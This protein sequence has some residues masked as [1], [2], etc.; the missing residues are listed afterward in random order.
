MEPPTACEGA[1]QPREEEPSPRLQRILT[2]LDLMPSASV[3]CCEAAASMDVEVFG[4]R[5]EA[6][7]EWALH[8]LAVRRAPS[9]R[10]PTT[11]AVVRASS[12]LA[13][14]RA[15]LPFASEHSTALVLAPCVGAATSSTEHSTALVLAPCAGAATSSTAAASAAEH[16]GV[17]ARALVLASEDADIERAVDDFMRAVPSALLLH[18]PSAVADLERIASRRRH[19]LSCG[20]SSVRAGTAFVR[21]WL[22]FCERRSL[23]S[24][25][26]PVDD[27]LLCVFFAEVDT[28]ARRRAEGRSRQTGASVLHAMACAARWVT[29]HAGLPF[30]A[31]KARL[32]RK[33]SAPARERDP[34]WSEMWEPSVVV[35]LL[36]V[37]AECAHRGL[38]RAMAASLFFVCTASMRLINGQRSAPPVLDGDGVFHGVAVLSKGKRRSSM[39][40]KPW[41]VPCV[42]PDSAMLDADV[43]RCL[44]E[45]LSSLP[46]SCC[47][48]FPRLIDERGREVS[49]ER[50]VAACPSARAA[51]SQLE[52][53]VT[54]LLTLPPLNL[55]RAEARQL[56]SRKHGPRHIFPEL[57]RVMGLPLSTPPWLLALLRSHKLAGTYIGQLE[58]AAAAAPYFSLPRDWFADRAVMHYIDNQGACYSLI[59][60]RA[61]DADANRIVF[62]TSMRLAR[63][64]CDAWYDYVPSASNIADLPTRLDTAAFSRLEKIADRMPLC[65]PPEWC[66]ACPHSQLSQLFD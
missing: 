21:E 1:L 34:A 61:R 65:L 64:R 22:A 52:T 60:G 35:H 29:D 24:Y 2:S 39:A 15:D 18:A 36:R 49:L 13:V 17:A 12:A 33:S 40:P 44:R 9:R 62:V 57:A 7:R 53:T 30:G 59:N 41:S 42:S 56:A 54:Y 8:E 51:S 38:V 25:G 3:L 28:A 14:A 16:A 26:L 45:A 11:V 46:A 37:S 58:L 48:M 66:L 63:L 55:P 10:A 19:L 50:A 23:D 4:E 47:S 31:A 6:V 20:A 32:V 5:T 43:E 27:D